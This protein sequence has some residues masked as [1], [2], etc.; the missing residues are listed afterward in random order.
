MNDLSDGLNFK[1]R[2]KEPE[3][4]LEPGMLAPANRRGASGTPRKAVERLDAI[5]PLSM[6]NTGG[7]GPTALQNPAAWVYD[8]DPATGS[9]RATYNGE[10]LATSI[11]APGS[12]VAS[13]NT[14]TGAV[15]LTAA[16]VTGVGGLV[17]PSPA[18]TGNPTAPTQ[19]P[20]DSDTSI[21]S[22][23]FVAQAV[24]ALA[25]VASFN[26]RTGAVAL[27]TGDIT[28]AGGAPVA[29]PA[30]TGN[31]QAPT[32]TAGDHS[33]SV[34]TTQFVANAIA[35]GAVASFNGRQ[36]IV[37]LTLSDVLSVGGAPIASPNFTG[38]PAGPTAAPGT[39][40][41]Q[42]AS[43]AFVTNA[44]TAAA[45]G[46]ASFNTRTG[47]VVLTTADVTSAGG[48]PILSP[49]FTGTPAAPTPTGG[50]SSTK[51]AT[52]A[53]VVNAISGAPANVTSFN[54]R[55][56]VVTLS[57][58]D[59]TSVG[60]APVA[61]PTFTGTPRTTTA[62]PGD[63][64][65]TIA[66][67]AFVAAAI[68]TAIAPLATS[69]SV[70]VV[71][72]TT[73]LMNGVAA[74]GASGKWADGA[75]VHPVDTSRAAQ[76]SLA[77]YLLLTGGTLTGAL[78]GS[79]AAFSGNVQG[80]T[81]LGGTVQ[82]GYP[83]FADFYAAASAAIKT[84]NFSASGAYAFQFNVANGNLAWVANS[85]AAMTI[86]YGGNLTIT[87]SGIKP[88]GGSWTATSDARI[89]TV[90]G[91]YTQGLA[92]VT[93]LR[94]V[95]YRYNGNDTYTAG[96]SSPHAKVAT[97]GQSFIGLIAQNAEIPMPEMVSA[98]TGFI[99]GVAVDDLRV[100]DTTPLIF[101]LV[102]AVKELSARIA[103]LEQMAAARSAMRT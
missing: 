37:N 51:I 11:T 28:S 98:M 99:D 68:T 30:F 33:S 86:D 53:F 96:Q 89:K 42:L 59:V 94:P 27:T 14:R 62:T 6:P 41:T 83:L 74:I 81:V 66:D 18:L 48:A 4:A 34:A 40:T 12:G 3:S 35:G 77:N 29:S 43:T 69:A 71:T 102:N 100:L 76:T 90:D 70:P 54:G 93:A 26:G 1:P 10:V 24:A 7:P 2:A 58:A 82:F 61:S 56:G 20:G 23:A 92:A 65:T 87:G 15:V 5:N 78:N 13:F 60:G 85:A 79:A 84:I 31:P 67:T 80:L 73:P 72:T 95:V 17:N 88:G 25:V 57:L 38:V 97:D 36:G 19:P 32:P 101:A 46:V 75:H 49:T 52:T 63:N 45:S 47:A 91:D 50:D 22:T 39:A 103:T 55:Q 64:S 8:F 21:A 9:S 16:D 44:V